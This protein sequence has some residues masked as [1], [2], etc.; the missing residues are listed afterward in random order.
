MEFFDDTLTK[1]FSEGLILNK[2]ENA[3][4]KDLISNVPINT[5]LSSGIDSSIIAYFAKKS[6][7]P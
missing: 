5:Y 1:R 2:I 7:K 4:N 3:V 6:K